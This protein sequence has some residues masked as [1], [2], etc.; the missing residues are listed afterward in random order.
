[1]QIIVTDV[2][3]MHNGHV[4]VAGWDLERKCMVRPLAGPGQH[5]AEEMAGEHLFE[6]GNV[7]QLVPSKARNTRG[8]PHAREDVIIKEEPELI[9]SVPP[10]QLP[11]R[12]AESEHASV[13]R[14]FAGHLKS[15]MYVLE[16]SDCPSLGAVSVDSR[17]MGFEER[18]KPKGPQ[19]RCWFY[20][21]EGVSYNFPVVS[22]T[23]RA[24]YEEGGLEAVV[25]LRKRRR[26]AH[27]RLGLANPFKDDGRCWVMVNN[28]LFY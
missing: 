9:G 19:L 6:M 1:M 18:E 22:R 27:V 26:L 8:L 24:M 16:G 4:C 25:E 17:R 11:S 2:T 21:A 20:D 5:W 12:L 10:A 28:V 13:R 14:L 23:I 3:L 7:V 15:G